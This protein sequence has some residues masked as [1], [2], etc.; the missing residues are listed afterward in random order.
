LPDIR[1]AVKTGRIFSNS[2]MPT[3]SSRLRR[4]VCAPA[5]PVFLLT[6]HLARLFQTFEAADIN[7]AAWKD[8]VAN[9]TA[10]V[11]L[12][13]WIAGT[14]AA[15]AGESSVSAILPERHQPSRRRGG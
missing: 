14:G 9:W 6:H 13:A 7:L 12:A 8:P 2:L 10:D 1:K 3:D 15:V 11:M 4:I 5:A